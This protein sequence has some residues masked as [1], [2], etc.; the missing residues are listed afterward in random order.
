MAA[1]PVQAS[2]TPSPAPLR[3]KR[4]LIDFLI[5]FA[6][7]KWVI[8]LTGL[9][10][11]VLGAGA[12]LLMSPVYR[13][14]SKFI[15]LKLDSP[16]SHNVIW[17][18]IRSRPVLDAVSKKLSLQKKWNLPSAGQTVKVLLSSVKFNYDKNTYGMML[19]A[20]AGDAALAADIANGVVE[21]TQNNLLAIHGDML[22]IV[23]KRKQALEAEMKAIQDGLAQS[24]KTL[25]K[26]ASSP[27][28]SADVG[29]DLLEARQ[30]S[31]D[32]D[33]SLLAKLPDGGVEYI[34]VV[35]SIR[36]AESLYYSTLTLFA[37]VVEQEKAEPLTLQVLERASAPETRSS[38]DRKLISILAGIL[39][40]LAGTL[41]VFLREYFRTA[42]LD[43]GR[44]VKMEELARAMR[45]R[46]AP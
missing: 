29:K 27:A 20:W 40:I 43:P 6:R 11:A 25:A 37:K 12:S 31:R 32:A 23:Q 34:S 26:I 35:R 22:A 17:E 30:S 7:N 46:Q 21:E 38:P 18:I 44:K 24:E 41:W 13:A 10:F 14:Q 15:P 16:I 19:T 36:T 42:A 33:A 9:L 3:D 4:D 8:L 5:L 28:I 45:M 39:G 2:S 1:E